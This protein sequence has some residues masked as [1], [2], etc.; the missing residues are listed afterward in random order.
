MERISIIKAAEQMGVSDQFLRVALQNNKF[1]FGTAIQISTNRWTY[2]IN[3]A[4][5][6]KFLRGELLCS[7][8]S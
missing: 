4:A 7:Y 1:P 5:F 3:P 2:Y 8:Q 6:E